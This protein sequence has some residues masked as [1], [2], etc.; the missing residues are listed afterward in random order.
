MSRDIGSDEVDFHA[1]TSFLRSELDRL[2]ADEQAVRLASTRS[3][4]QWAEAAVG[5]AAE[6]L[7]I[8]LGFLSGHLIAVYENVRGGF[9]TGWRKGLDRGRGR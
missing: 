6:G 3:F 7:G 8:T 9:S 4:A 1:L 2:D 5:R